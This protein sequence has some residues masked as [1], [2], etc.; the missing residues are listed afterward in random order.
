M[1]KPEAKTKNTNPALLIQILLYIM[2]STLSPYHYRIS[3]SITAVTVMII[4]HHQYHH[5]RHHVHH[6]HHHCKADQ[7]TKTTLG[8]ADMECVN[9]CVCVCVC[10]IIVKYMQFIFTA[11]PTIQLSNCCPKVK[12]KDYFS[13]LFPS[14][15]LSFP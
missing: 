15:N 10:D 12:K 9:M 7:R 3:I 6:Q 2:S 4:T 11:I 5:H 1:S 8:W 13:N 14:T